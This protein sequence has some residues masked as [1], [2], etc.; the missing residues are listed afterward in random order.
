M[1]GVCTIK[2]IAR[3]LGVAHSTVSRVL[4]NA[5]SAK[6]VSASMRQKI[7]E[8]VARRGYVPNVNARRLVNAKSNLVAIVLP[9]NDMA[10][11][12]RPVI[13]DRSLA[14]AMG[15]MADVFKQHD[16]RMLLIF[17]DERFVS[18]REY[19]TL[20]KEKSIDGMI[21]WGARNNERY[22]DEAA[23]FNIVMINS[24]NGK[25]SPIRYIGSDNYHAAYECC[26][27]LISKG[28]RRI[29]YLD[30]YEGVSIS[31][32][33][34]AGYRKALEDAGIPFR[35][36][37]CF[38]GNNVEECVGQILDF[39]SGNADGF[40]AVQC[41]NDKVAAICGAEL[42]KRGCRIPE[43]ISLAG[44]DRIDD[45]YALPLT[46]HV[47]MISFRLPCLKMGE[48]AAQWVLEGAAGGKTGRRNL[49]L[50]VEMQE[51]DVLMPE[52]LRGRLQFGSAEH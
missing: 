1:E 3:E 17:N 44:G 28:R 9:A 36:K 46:W 38:K 32:E 6:V 33:R 45:P 35:K 22:W 23:S 11:P 26:R 50:P 20:F 12:S 15:G 5:P 51:M 4:S 39:H 34:F 2:E 42:M 49:L 37:L 8:T 25:D 41:I 24:L 48:L 16:Y 13:S 31:D 27:L 7:M 30:S 43:D 21:V 52:A 10:V 29:A 47:P 14:E 40:D 19:I 18:K